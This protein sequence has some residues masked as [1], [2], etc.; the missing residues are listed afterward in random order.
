MATL[1]AVIPTLHAVEDVN[2]IIENLQK[3]VPD[4]AVVIVDNGPDASHEGWST[5]WI[6]VDP[7]YLGSEGGF[8]RG[9]ALARD[10]VG[11]DIHCLTLDHDAVFEPEAIREMVRAAEWYPEAAISARLDPDERTLWGGGE[12]LEHGALRIERAP[13]SAMLLSPAARDFILAQPRC[14]HF[15]YGEDLLYTLRMHDA[16]IELIGLPG[17]R[18]LNNTP[19]EVTPWRA[20]YRTRNRFLIGRDL[21]WGLG[22]QTRWGIN[23]VRM[24]VGH[25]RRGKWRMAAATVRGVIDGLFNRRGARMLPK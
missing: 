8:L 6:E 21:S 24:I 5:G 4:V 17:V 2:R 1:V 10:F 18:V 12:L 15:F 19:R 3:A 7:T 25:A 9:L 11:A 20:Y 16:G 22:W 23:R 14:G 13:W